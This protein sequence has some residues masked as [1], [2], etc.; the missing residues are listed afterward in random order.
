M[1]LLLLL[2]SRKMAPKQAHWD[3]TQTSTN[4]RMG[5]MVG[6]ILQRRTQK[7]LVCVC[8]CVCSGLYGNEDK[9]SYR[10]R[11]DRAHGE[12]AWDWSRR[13]EMWSVA[14]STTSCSTRPHTTTT[15]TT[16]SRRPTDSHSAS[17]HVT[18]MTSPLWWRHTAAMTSG[19]NRA[20][21]C[22]CC[23]RQDEWA[24]C[25]GQRSRYPASIVT[26]VT[27][28]VYVCLPAAV[29][30]LWPNPACKACY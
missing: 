14:W 3:G 19:G 18:P 15:T 6:H 30:D 25:K 9:V 17:R 2:F 23:N 10:W 21:R 16:T 27:I 20:I 7:M 22:R 12:A 29:S 4:F 13:T 28:S 8:V 5:V 24:E 26:M 11:V 1:L